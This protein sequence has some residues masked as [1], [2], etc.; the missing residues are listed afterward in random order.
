MLTNREQRSQ[1]TLISRKGRAAPLIVTRSIEVGS[2]FNVR[3]Q[4]VGGLIEGLTE[5]GVRKVIPA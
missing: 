4:H 1:Q 5:N 2:G 3:V